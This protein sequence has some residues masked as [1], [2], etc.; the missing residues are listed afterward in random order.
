MLAAVHP[1]CLHSHFL[2]STI[3]ARQRYLTADVRLR[4]IALPLHPPSIQMSIIRSRLLP[5]SLATVLISSSA[6]LFSMAYLHWDIKNQV[7]AI[8]VWFLPFVSLL[9]LLLWCAVSVHA[10]PDMVRSMLLILFVFFV[11]LIASLCFP[12]VTAC[13]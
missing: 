7:Q 3:S 11:L 5:I 12:V 13:S 1:E 8:I 4:I 9:G 2:R 6:L 10:M